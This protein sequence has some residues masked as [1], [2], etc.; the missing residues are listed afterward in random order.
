[1][2]IWLSSLQTALY[3]KLLSARQTVANE[4]LIPPAV[5]ATNKILVEMARVR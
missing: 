4:K 5:L 3:G 1:M 2:R